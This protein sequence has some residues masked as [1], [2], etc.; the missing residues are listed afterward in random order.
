MKKV[1][2]SEKVTKVD[3]SI[4]EFKVKV[5]AEGRATIAVQK[6]VTLK[7][8]D[9][10]FVRFDLYAIRNVDDADEA[11]KD[12]FDNLSEL[13]TEQLQKEIESVE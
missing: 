2:K 12:G 4:E 5:P 8:G 7:I 6:G 10:E 11:I 13:L 9:F 1:K 3:T